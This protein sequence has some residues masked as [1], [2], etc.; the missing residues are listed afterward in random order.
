M[1]EGA[2]GSG[3]QGDIAIDD[4]SM[5]P[6]CRPA[7][8]KISPYEAV[9]Y[10]QIHSFYLYIHDYHNNPK[11]WERQALANSVNPDQMPHSVASDQGLHCLPL[12]QQYSK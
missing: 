8:R 3:Y 9:S 4:V 7:A 11:Y 1:I 6:G 2:V 10:E 12:I 5:T